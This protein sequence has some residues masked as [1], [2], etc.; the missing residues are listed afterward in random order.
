MDLPV[1][2]SVIL[3]VASAV[4]LAL[5]AAGETALERASNARIQALA[6]RGDEGAIRIAD[7][8]ER[9]ER[10][11]DPLTTARIVSASVLLLAFAYVG[12]RIDG[13]TGVVWLGALGALTVAVLQMTVGLLV[14][15]RPEYTA[16]QLSRVIRVTA[17]G[18]GVIS[19][20]LALPAKVIGRTFQS[21]APPPIDDFLALVEREEASGGVEEEERRMIRGIIDLED[22]TAREIMVPRIDV[23]GA[24]IDNTVGDVAAL[25][26]ERGFSRIPI[27][28]ENIDDIVGIVYAK[29]LLR[30]V[31]NGSR[32]RTLA[33]LL[34]QPVFIPESKRLDQLLTEM[35]ASRTHMAIVVDEYG[36]TAGLVTIEDLL[37]EIVG[38][39]EDEYDTAAP[40]IERISEDEVL[41]DAG[42]PTETLQEMFDCDIDSEDFDTVG[43]LVIH[44]LGRLPDVGDEVEV[45]D[46]LLSVLSMNGRRIKRVRVQRM[47]PETMELAA[48]G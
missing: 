48:E 2:V 16:V 24:E 11:L 18:F 8:E 3:M 29:D 28:R 32:E 10:F 13:G 36:G 41:L 42:S 14:A 40:P 35:R 44:E 34:R 31:S 4:I 27:F 47:Q 1:V 5:V 21:V 46:L 26:N 7:S 6:A 9:L 30:S 17:V 15:K 39:I 37:E 23:A 38:E 20:L 19:W 25:I 43:G 45:G 12:S 33:E 22:K